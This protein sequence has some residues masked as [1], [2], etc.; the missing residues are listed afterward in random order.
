MGKD[1]ISREEFLIEFFGLIGRE[2]GDPFQKFS[3]NPS[4]ILQFVEGCKRDKKPAFMSVQPRTEHEKVYG[5]EKLFFDFDYGKKSDNLSEKKIEKRKIKLDYEI[6]VFIN[7]VNKFDTLIKPLIVKTRKGY[8][9]YIYFDKIYEIDD[10]IEHWRRV[11]RGLQEMFINSVKYEFKFL[12]PT[13]LG[14]IKRLARIPTSIHEKSGEECLILDE[15]FEPTKI[16]SVNIYKGY[17]LQEK[18]IRMID[19]FVRM[20]ELHDKELFKLNKEDQKGVWEKQH[21]YVGKIRP[22]FQ[23]RM[24]MG[25]MCH[26]Q[27]LA[28]LIEAYYAGYNKVENMFE[29]FRCFKD[30]D[31]RTTRYQVE[32]FFKNKVNEKRH[33]C[34]TFP[35]K[36][37]T[38]MNNGW[39]LKEECQRYQ[40][41]KKKVKKDE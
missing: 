5:L 35:Y 21:G 34:Y 15:K 4:D 2:L 11:Y 33:R 25:E 36:C 31:E 38:I 10:D 17:G 3:N 27:R 16:R 7:T 9:V 41:I 23:K 30:F 19:R 24:D 29:L 12:D 13:I 1:H 14:D 8:H 18:H 6:K 20:K 37:E 26:N 22:C 28:L 39:C 32:W 40:N